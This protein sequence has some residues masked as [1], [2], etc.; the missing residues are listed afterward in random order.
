MVQY[1]VVHVIFK[2]TFKKG[3]S[4]L[5]NAEKKKKNEHRERPWKGTTRRPWGTSETIVPFASLDTEDTLQRIT[6]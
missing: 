5:S 6:E 1:K 2:G 3:G 4:A